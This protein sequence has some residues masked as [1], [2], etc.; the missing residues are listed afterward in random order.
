M[1]TD[2]NFFKYRFSFCHIFAEAAGLNEIVLMIFFIKLC[3]SVLIRYS[4][5]FKKE[6][7]SFSK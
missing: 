2:T 4:G 1:V 6:F 7:A 5:R 3:K